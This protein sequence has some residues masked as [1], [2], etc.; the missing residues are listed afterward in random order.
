MLKRLTRK[1]FIR[2]GL[3]LVAII[4]VVVTSSAAPTPTCAKNG[5]IWY[6]RIVRYTDV[7]LNPQARHLYWEEI[8]R[9]QLKAN[10]LHLLLLR[11]AVC[12]GYDS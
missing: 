5:C 9:L 10:R 8:F 2:R 4:L 1:L 7:T 3:P 11:V 6:K 12:A